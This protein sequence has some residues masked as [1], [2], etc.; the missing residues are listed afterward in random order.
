MCNLDRIYAL[1]VLESA[2]LGT[3]PL[4]SVR[5]E[6]QDERDAYRPSFGSRIALF[7]RSRRSQHTSPVLEVQR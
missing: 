1:I 4:K 5:N 6:L 7:M 3:Q 2:A